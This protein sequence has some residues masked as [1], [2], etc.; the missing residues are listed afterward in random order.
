MTLR[1]TMQEVHADALKQA[2]V[3]PCKGDGRCLWHALALSLAL[4]GKHSLAQR[5]LDQ[6]SWR[7]TNLV[8]DELW[9]DCR[10]TLKS[11]YLPFWAPGE[12]GVDAA[13]PAD[14]VRGVRIGR[15]FAGALELHAASR[16]L[17]QCSIYVFDASKEGGPVLVT[18]HG[19][20]PRRL[21]LMR[22]HLHYDALS[23]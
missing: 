4:S 3:W 22:R 23:F 7:L 19:T 17:P 18:V 12:P 5:S 15:I 16:V 20:G 14:Y 11:E 10:Q 8:C 2:R 21:P 6:L 9:D 13:T 1:T